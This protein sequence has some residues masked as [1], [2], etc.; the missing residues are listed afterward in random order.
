MANYRGPKIIT[1]GL[2]F[3]IDG[4]NIKSFNSGS[5][6]NDVLNMIDTSQTGS[7]KSGTSFSD[8]VFEFDGT[9]D[10]IDFGDVQDMGT[11]DW[12][13]EAWVSL[14]GD[15]TGYDWLISKA[16][17]NVG[18][19]R[20]A[21]GLDNTRKLRTFFVGSPQSGPEGSQITGD[22]QLAVDT[23]YYVVWTLDRSSV[24]ELY[25][26]GVKDSWTDTGG[27]TAGNDISEWNG[28]DMQNNHTLKIGAYT[29]S[30]NTG[31]QQWAYFKLANLRIHNVLLTQSEIVN[32]YNATKHRFG[33]KS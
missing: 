8:G 2:I 17:A 25:I 22:T 12:T 13:V 9:D 7:L 31:P 24:Q 14:S 11:N 5:A 1:D 26:N 4:V 30:A 33:I 21:L 15:N 23:W 19:Y 16:F 29:N 27:S 3:T 18:S 32:N 10:Y 6:P 20:W 28:Q